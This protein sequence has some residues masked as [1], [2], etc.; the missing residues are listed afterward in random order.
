MLGRTNTGGGGGGGG[1]N[2][3]VVGNPQ[4]TNPKVNTIWVDT[5]VEITSWYFS[6]TEPETA[7]QGMVW[8]PTSASS[9]VEFNALKKNGVQVYPISAKQYVDGA[10]VAVTAKTRQN[11]EWV[12]W[13]NGELFIDGNQ[14]THI[15]GGWYNNT[16]LYVKYSSTYENTGAV[17]SFDTY[18]TVTAKSDKSANAT[19]KNAIDLTNFSRLSYELS[20]DSAENNCHLAV[21]KL[22]T[23]DLANN[24]VAEVQPTPGTKGTLNI[25]NLK[26]LYYITIFTL[27][28]RTAK[29]GNI[30][31]E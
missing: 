13:W 29:F 5:D 17:P 10:W 19:T 12:D 25:S 23:G 16:G 28:N 18:I 8:F 11:G 14:Y 30:R 3:T 9:T 7:T 21:H 4:P 1:L 2:F 31:L 20:S 26:G 6:A 22:M 24:M 15:T 27:N